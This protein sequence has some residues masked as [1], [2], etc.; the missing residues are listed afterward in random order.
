MPALCLVV[1]GAALWL[2]RSDGAALA[3]GVALVMGAVFVAFK[4][5]LHL[6]GQK[7][8]VA[9]GLSAAGAT[10]LV[11]VVRVTAWSVAR[12][13]DL[14]FQNTAQHRVQIRQA[15][16]ETAT[17]RPVASWGAGTFIE[18]HLP[19]ATRPSRPVRS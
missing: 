1:Q 9:A 6:C 14:V 15:E 18:A 3:I 4:G 5:A 10:G 13:T 12:A 19:R 2:T 7:R 11:M 16:V 8:P 17:M